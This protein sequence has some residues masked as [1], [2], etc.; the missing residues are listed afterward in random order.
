MSLSDRTAFITG[1]SRGIGL[2]VA[3]ALL[4]EGARV[5]ITA[6][7]EEGVERAARDLGTA[8][9]SRVLGIKADVRNYDEVAAAIARAADRFSG[10]DVLVNN[11]GVGTFTPVAQMTPADWHRVIDTNLTGVFNCCHESH[12]SFRTL[13]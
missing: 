2:A 5:A 7:S 12:M 1:G 9:S 13:G 8:D 4:Q 10:F 3:R 6:T 11:A